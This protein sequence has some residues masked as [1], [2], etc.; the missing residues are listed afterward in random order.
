MDNL[1]IIADDLTGAAD[2]GVQFSPFFDETTLVSYR[3][4]DP[5]MDLTRPSSRATVVYT[6]SRA[7]AAD[8]AHQ[9][10]VSAAGWLGREGYSWIYKKIDSCMR[11]NVGSETDA[12]LDKLEYV[13]SF[14]TPAFPEMGRTT[15]DDI[16]YVHGVPLDQ[17][18]ISRDP[19]TP[20]KESRLSL[21][22]KSQSKRPVGHVGLNFLDGS[23][24]RL[25]EE[26]ERQLFS[27]TRHIVFDATERYH[28]DRIAK[29][30]FSSLH[31]IL[32]VGSAGLAGSIAKLLTSKPV[33]DRFP[34]VNAHGGF[35]LLVCGTAST[36][37]EQQIETLLQNASYRVFQ[38]DPL[39]LAG[40]ARAHELTKLTS[41]IRATLL[42]NNV[43]L[44][45]K[46][47]QDG[48]NTRGETNFEPTGDSIVRG[49]GLLV[50]DVV[51]SANPGNLFLT[52]G[53][54]ADGVLTAFKAEG[55]RILGEVVA[56]VVQGVIIG[57][58][59]DGLPVVTK[60]GAFGKKDTLVAVHEFWRGLRQGSKV[61][62]S[63]VQGCKDQ[64]QILNHDSQD[65]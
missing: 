65:S 61:H 9:R 4:M 41:L 28:L 8:A 1:V 60:A 48:R 36:V 10:L 31:K 7:L 15:C 20:V 6:N 51:K 19:I 2:T 44:T 63:E 46:P 58:D 13:V 38:P 14:I 17:T 39:I 32:P 3:R 24:D 43:I 12:L 22:V 59:L 42:Q 16:H 56:G 40:R 52:G 29:L 54:T 34:V 47:Q 30:I 18:E 45:I 27:G 37:A 64:N 21:I 26:I 62:G 50:A 25:G 23:Q 53:D 11:G 55:I 35:N 49:L 33:S 57:G 5:K